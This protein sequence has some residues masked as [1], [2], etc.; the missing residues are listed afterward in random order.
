M[1]DRK[2]KPAQSTTRRNQAGVVLRRPNTTQK[3]CRAHANGKNIKSIHATNKIQ[4]IHSHQQ[5]KWPETA[6]CSAYSHGHSTVTTTPATGANH[7]LIVSL[8]CSNV[9]KSCV[10]LHQS[11]AARTARHDVRPLSARAR[12]CQRERMRAQAR[13]YI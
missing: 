5:R 9:S 8:K 13:E 3:A 1:S 4:R 7:L 6:G 10:F 12:P 11:I 2:E